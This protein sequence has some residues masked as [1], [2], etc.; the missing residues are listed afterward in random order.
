MAITID[1]IKKTAK[2]AKFEITQ[3]EANL[4]AAQLSAVLDWAAQLQSVDTSAT[5]AAPVQNSAPLRADKAAINPAA[6]AI[7]AAFNDRENNL[8]RVKKVL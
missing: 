4:Y 7:T 3:E 5:A 6:P 8:L 2:L 1:E